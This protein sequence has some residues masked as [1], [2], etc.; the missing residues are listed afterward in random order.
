MPRALE[1][2]DKRLY[3]VWDNMKQ[4]CNNANHYYY[5]DYGGRGIGYVAEWESFDAFYEWAIQGYCEKLSLDR[6]DNEEGYGPSNCKWATAKEQAN[7]RRAR[8]CFKKE[9][10]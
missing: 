4:R 5:P 3:K 1:G 7:N 8:S 9:G 6:I 10:A 2:S